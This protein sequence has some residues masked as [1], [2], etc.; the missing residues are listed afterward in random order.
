MD[1]YKKSVFMASLL[2]L[3][4]TIAGIAHFIY[5]ERLSAFYRGFVSDEFLNKL[6]PFLRLSME[7]RWSKPWL[8]TFGAV[9]VAV[10]LL[11]MF[12]IVRGIMYG[13]H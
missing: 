1:D 4:L 7:S 6:P 13:E 10:G 2:S 8:R 12:V 3:L 9:C 5:A 11:L